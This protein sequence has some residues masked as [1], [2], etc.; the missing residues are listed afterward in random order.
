MLNDKFIFIIVF[1]IAEPAL[2][3]FWIAIVLL[4]DASSV[5]E[6]CVLGVHLI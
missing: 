5:V 6:L 2:V 4:L 3:M 1:F